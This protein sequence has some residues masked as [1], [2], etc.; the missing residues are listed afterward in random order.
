MHI[1]LLHMDNVALPG[2][3]LKEKPTERV[4][5]KGQ[6]KNGGYLTEICNIINNRDNKTIIQAE[7]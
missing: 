2:D 4:E 5:Y 3:K 6:A 1:T 7:N